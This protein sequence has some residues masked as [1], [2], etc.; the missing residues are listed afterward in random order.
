M[1]VGLLV[2]LVLTC[3]AILWPLLN[4]L[5]WAALLAFVTWPVYHRVRRRCRGRDSLAA[6]LTTLLVA[7]IIIGPLSW[8]ALLLQSQLAQVYQT[9]AAYNGG[10]VLVAPDFMRGIPWLGAQIQNALDRYSADPEQLRQ[11]LMD[12]L[13]RLRPEIFGVVGGMGRFI[14]AL[15]V[16]LIIC[17]FLFRD[18][19]KLARQAAIVIHH[20]FGNRLDRY[21]LAAAAVTRAVV[22]GLLATALI[23]GSVAALGYAIFGVGIPIL[24]GALTAVASVVPVIGTFLVW[25]I[26][27]VWLIL[28][29]HL[30]QGVGL[31]IWGTALVNPVDNIL[32]PLL[33]SNTAHI[34]FL[35]VMF[36][37]IGGGTAFGLVGVFIGPVVLAVAAAAWREWIAGMVAA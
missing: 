27:S 16:T 37:V 19:S 25:G 12:G 11:L 21:I 23:Q 15:S 29:G 36:G 24:L 18:G 26:V 5:A 8:F 14:L 10:V 4:P 9:I 31:L 1:L 32:R 34:P 2:G 7:A 33:I 28:T 20:Y 3:T 17:F 6:G 13:Q 30:W 35:L 22:Q